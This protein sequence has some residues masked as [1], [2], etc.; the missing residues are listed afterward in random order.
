MTLDALINEQSLAKT[1]SGNAI[2][3]EDRRI[4]PAGALF[5]LQAFRSDIR[6]R[7]Y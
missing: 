7:K 4:L 5:I 6:R 2:L 3:C 1:L